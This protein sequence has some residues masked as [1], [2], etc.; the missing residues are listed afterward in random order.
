MMPASPHPNARV[1][2]AVDRAAD[3]YFDAVVAASPMTATHLGIARHQDEID[4]LSLDGLREQSTL[5]RRTLAELE[6]AQPVDD[7]DRVTVEA[8]RERLGLAEEIHAAGLDAMELNNIASPMQ[9]VRD[10]LDLM[11]TDSEEQWATI[12]RRIA[13]IP[14][15]LTQYVESLE[16]AADQGLVAS[17]RQVEVCID[18][19]RELA[20]DDAYLATLPSTARVGRAEPSDSLR[21]DL[22]T[23]TDAARQAYRDLADALT[24]LRERAPEELGCGRERYQLYSRSFLGSTVDLEETYAWGQEELARITALMEETAQ[25]IRP[26][27][28]VKEAIAALD[29]DPAYRLEGTDALK[30]WMQGKA[31]EAV[32]ALAGTHF[33]VPKPIRTI[34]CTHRPDPDRRHLLHGPSDD[35]SRPGRMWWSVPKGVTTFG[36]WRELTTVYHEGVPGH[37]LQVG[38]TVYRQ[39]PAQPVAPPRSSWTSGHGEGWALYAEWLMAELGYMEDPGNLMGLLDG[40]SLR[41]ARVVLD[42][43]VHCE[44]RG[45]GRGRWRAP[46]PTTRRGRSSTPHAQ[47]DH[48]LSC[49][50]SSIDTSAGPGRHRAT[51]SAS[52]LWTE[53]RAEVARR[54]GDAFDLADFHR[55]ALDVGSTGLDVLSTAVLG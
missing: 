32:A 31:D 52:G 39:R 1:P 28:G 34:E 14:T 50:S 43:G 53:L 22:K 5:R 44:L 16:H 37:H 48:R 9:S 54:E 33:D 2:T 17:R 35:L 40:Q 41:A 25:R 10:V 12:S 51:R 42:V 21:S 49:A 45:A 26:G 7:V 38:Q 24:R 15:A 19:A 18:Q 55:R 8:M 11:P 4:D 30:A 6:A 23:S 46:G 13:A 20:D 29:E 36:T 27:A 47:P 3:A